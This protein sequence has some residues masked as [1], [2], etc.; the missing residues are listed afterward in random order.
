MIGGRLSKSR[1]GD[2]DPVEVLEGEE[3]LELS[4]DAPKVDEEISDY[5]WDRMKKQAPKEWADAANDYGL[6]G[7]LGSMGGMLGGSLVSIA[8]PQIGQM[9]VEGSI[10][11]T[12]PSASAMVGGRVIGKD[13]EE[14]RPD[15]SGLRNFRYAIGDD[16]N[17][18]EMMYGS[19]NVIVDTPD[20]GLLNRNKG[21]AFRTDGETVGDLYTEVMDD[22]NSRYRENE[23][24]QMVRY[25]D[26]EI[27]GELAEAENWEGSMDSN[28]QVSVYAEGDLEASFYADTEVYP[29]GFERFTEDDV[30]EFQEYACKGSFP[31]EEKW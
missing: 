4:E 21:R 19:E 10:N 17:A 8:D 3:E 24:L 27:T 6:L 31:V 13:L 28:V 26:A 18:A 12:V 7:L 14:G 20:S 29:E 30:E 16:G 22:L 9:I 23:V 25:A 11:L 5:R 1:E 2:V 15:S